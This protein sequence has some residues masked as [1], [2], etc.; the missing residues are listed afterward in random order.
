[1]NNVSATVFIKD[2]KIET[3]PFMHYNKDTRQDE[4]DTLYINE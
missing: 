3:P 1:M 2:K 4:F